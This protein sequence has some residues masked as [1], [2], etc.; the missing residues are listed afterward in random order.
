M[1]SECGYFGDA[2]ID[3]EIV[4]LQ[5]RDI[6]RNYF[7]PGRIYI[8]KSSVA[9]MKNASSPIKNLFKMQNHSFIQFIYVLNTL[10]LNF[11]AH[12]VNS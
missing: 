3:K 12:L 6:S 11:E 8:I 2:I 5:N 4:P 1:Q 9:I 7:L 10:K